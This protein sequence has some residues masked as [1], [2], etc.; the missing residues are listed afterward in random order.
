MSTLLEITELNKHYGS[1]IALSNINL[2]IEKAAAIGLVGKNGAGKTTLLSILSGALRANTGSISI[3]GETPESIATT[4]KL[5]VL[6]QDATFKKGIP[7]YKQLVFFARLQ[8]MSKIEANASVEKLLN[9][10]GDA[11]FAEQAPETMSYGQRKRLGILQ[12]FLGF[13][14]LVILDEPTAGLDPIVAND[15]RQLIRKLS[16]QTAFI[17]SS[18]NLYEI[19]DICSSVIILDAGKLIA[20]KQISQL[21]GNENKL[22][23]TL[24][25][26][27]DEK[28]LQALLALPEIIDL[29]QDSLNHEKI[30]LDLGNT[31]PDELQM[32]IQRLIMDHG[33]AITDLSRHKGLIDG[34]MDLVDRK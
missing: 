26:E 14:Q 25:R 33:Y 31:S 11:Q 15:V 3:L 2:C 16:A 34:L 1:T 10:F 6:P 20:S 19:E 28:L 21:R 32:Q 4:G 17:I 23:L 22:N 7:V 8:G 30:S 24:N 18:H 9:E 29:A 27:A 13:P 5:N 12:A